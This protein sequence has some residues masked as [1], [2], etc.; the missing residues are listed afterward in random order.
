M[1]DIIE[2]TSKNV[3]ENRKNTDLFMMLKLCL[4]NRSRKLPFPT[5]QAEAL[6]SKTINTVELAP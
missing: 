5:R 2:K 4:R 6:V 3:I 1:G